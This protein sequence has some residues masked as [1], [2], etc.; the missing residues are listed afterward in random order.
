MRS[1]RHNKVRGG[2]HAAADQTDSGKTRVFMIVFIALVVLA[3]LVTGVR[4]AAAA[5]GEKKVFEN[6]AVLKEEPELTE[7]DEF[8][9]KF[10]ESERA[11]FMFLGSADGLTDTIMV[12][13]YDMKNQ[14]VDLISVP[15]D[16]YYPRPG[17]SGAWSKINSIYHSKKGGVTEVA[18]AVSD[19]LDGMPIH[20][21]MLID[22]EGVAN[23]VDAIG[24]VKFN[25]PFHMKYDDTTKG[26]E[27]HI[28]IPSGEQLLTK[29]NVVQF[30]RFR[31]TNPWYKR[32]GYKDYGSM[33]VG[34]METH[35]AF[36]KAAFKQSLG[37]NFP[38]VVGAVMDNVESDLDM[39]M[40]WKLVTKA[41][42][43]ESESITSYTL[44]GE[45]KMREGTSVWVLD[46]DGVE[47]MLKEIYD[48]TDA[49][50]EDDGG[51]AAGSGEP[52]DSAG[53]A[54]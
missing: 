31:Q 33:D 54:A 28:D 30:L 44:P 51:G 32:Q 45:P 17:Y 11:N 1:D 35:Q 16:T 53:N 46:E 20:Y 41:G 29:K 42:G 50:G 6:E 25:V 13:S 36:M 8:V 26:H 4:A 7:K 21:Y 19:V 24:G 23:I 3:V 43:L 10:G 9:E 48:R 34:R 49:G 15:R 47:E 12:A 18:K 37:P 39:D 22:Y 14:R 27:L 38:K 2:R 40:V 52:G 5:L